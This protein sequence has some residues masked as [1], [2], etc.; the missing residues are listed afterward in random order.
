MIAYR[1][2]AFKKCRAADRQRIKDR[3]DP[4]V[5]VRPSIRERH[6]TSTTPI[7]VPF[8]LDTKVPA[9][10]GYIAIRDQSGNKQVH[11]LEQ[12]VGEGS[13]FHFDL[14]EWDGK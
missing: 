10:S 6:T 12:M 14:V 1:K 5:N 4:E 2:L 9:K 13:K 11:K 3:L 8:S 7:N